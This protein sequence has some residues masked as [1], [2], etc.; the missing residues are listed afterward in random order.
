VI[1]LHIALPP[2]EKGD[3]A[4]PVA[5]WQTP[6]KTPPIEIQTTVSCM[7]ELNKRS[8]KSKAILL[9]A[10]F[11][12]SA[13]YPP[14]RCSGDL[15]NCLQL[16]PITW[17]WMSRT[18]KKKSALELTCRSPSSRALPHKVSIVH[19][20]PLRPSIVAILFEMS[21]YVAPMD[22]LRPFDPAPYLTF[23]QPDTVLEM[24]GIGLS[25]TGISPVAVAGPFP[26]FSQEAVQEMRDELMSDLVLKSCKYGSDPSFQLRGA[27][28]K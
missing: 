5:A 7:N 13:V 15:H 4:L 18:Y 1:V 20:S 8:P 25:G 14:N 11:Q 23:T 3:W 2:P 19:V 21:R 6:T 27:C 24:A 16:L 9:L 22:L 26:L 12:R 28:P 17:L 10:D